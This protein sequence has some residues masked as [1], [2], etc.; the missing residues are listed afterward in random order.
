M[1]K[2]KKTWKRVSYYA[3]GFISYFTPKFVHR[4][5]MERLLETLSPAE[6]EQLKK[7]VNY[8]C[9]FEGNPKLPAV[10]LYPEGKGPRMVIL[11]DYKFPW[12]KKDRHSRYFI[13]LY[14]AI[15]SFPDDYRMFYLYGDIISE[16]DYPFFVKSRPIKE[17]TNSVLLKLNKFRHFQWVNDKLSF[18]QKKDMAV[19]R[20]CVRNQPH[21]ALLLEKYFHHPMCNFGMT[22]QDA[23]LEHP[24]W[25]REFMSQAEQLTYKFIL[26]IEGNDVATNLKWVMSSNSL[27]V[28][29]RPKY[30]TWYMEGTLIPNYHYVLIKDDYSDLIERMQYYIEH[31]DE[32]EE[33]IRHAHEYVKQFQNGHLEKALIYAVAKE[34]FNRLH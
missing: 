18:S 10:N 2:G 27:A 29:P 28:M 14:E 8:Y 17:V 30:E 3:N 34:Y 4:Y 20:N 5:R 21:R 32:A 11:K 13:D 31:P 23:Y 19:S 6:S 25:K 9:R 16:Y 33:I 26:C 15:N 7:R 22:N 24:E 1:G 12:F